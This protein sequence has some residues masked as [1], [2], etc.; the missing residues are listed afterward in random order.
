MAEPDAPA[1]PLEEPE[2]GAVLLADAKMGHFQQHYFAQC[3]I[4][5]L[6]HGEQGSLG[7]ILNRPT[8]FTVEGV[9]AEP[10]E[11]F[12]ARFA[13]AAR[14]RIAEGRTLGLLWVRADTSPGKSR[15]RRTVWSSGLS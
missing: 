5:L 11:S 1:L 15:D 3:V 9:A 13:G 7:I 8:P 14:A 2:P 12:V 10:L 4:L 6:E